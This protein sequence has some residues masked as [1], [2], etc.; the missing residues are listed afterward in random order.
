MSDELEARDIR[1]APFVWVG[2]ETWRAFAPLVGPYAMAVYMALAYHANT[3]Q[4]AWPSSATIAHETGMGR[5]KVVAML[6]LL[7]KHRLIERHERLGQSTVYLLLSPAPGAPMHV[8]QGTH[9]CG[10]GVEGEPM[11]VVQGTPARGAP[12]QH[13]RTTRRTVNNKKGTTGDVQNASPPS[14]AVDY[15]PVTPRE[16][17]RYALLPDR[18]PSE[19]VKV[20]LQVAH[21]VGKD[22]T[23]TDF[24]QQR[25]DALILPEHI[26]KWQTVCEEWAAR[27]YKMQNIDGILNVFQHGWNGGGRGRTNQTGRGGTNDV[28]KTPSQYTPD[29]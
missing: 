16:R 14:P 27:G 12:E 19:A 6:D 25:I 11:H 1:E 5:R 15:D 18:E 9:A 24:Y 20:W 21:A 17:K 7:C 4:K 22:Q 28:I 23:A 8:V 10:A 29:A 3:G 26:P 13:K 2:K